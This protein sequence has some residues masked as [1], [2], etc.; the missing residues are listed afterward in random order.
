LAT[1]TATN[2]AVT[3]SLPVS[4]VRAAEKLAWEMDLSV[5]EVI[6]LALEEFIK[7]EAPFSEERVQIAKAYADYPDEGERI[8]QRAVIADMQRD[9]LEDEENP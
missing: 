5:N 3:V 6:Q 7:Q 8:W 2:A 1:E 4:L 9:L